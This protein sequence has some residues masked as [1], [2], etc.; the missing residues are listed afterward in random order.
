M[1]VALLQCV[2]RNLKPNFKKF[3]FGQFQEEK[4]SNYCFRNCSN[5]FMYAAKATITIG[6]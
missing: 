6:S 3:A 2:K 1:F 4:T 5:P